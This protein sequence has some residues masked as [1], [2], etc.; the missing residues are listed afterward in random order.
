[1]FRV[2]NVFGVF[3]RE[4]RTARS[5]NYAERAGQRPGNQPQSRVTPNNCKEKKTE[6]WLITH[7]P[8]KT[9]TN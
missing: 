3:G 9:K 1:V 7:S 5:L 4:V 6:L 2:L 8:A